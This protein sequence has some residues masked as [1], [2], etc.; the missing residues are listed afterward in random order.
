MN[1]PFGTTQSGSMRNIP[2]L[3]P[4][5]TLLLGSAPQRL[6]ELSR[7]RGWVG[8]KVSLL[9]TSDRGEAICTTL[10]FDTTH[11]VS[12]KNSHFQTNACSAR[13]QRE[14][15]HISRRVCTG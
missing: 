12:T 9:M 1:R 11:S 4:L 7:I 2:D 3:V 10:L 5:L 14:D 6:G 15:K 13:R 8:M